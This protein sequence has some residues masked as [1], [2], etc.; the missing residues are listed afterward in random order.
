MKEIK[1]YREG[2]KKLKTLKDIEFESD[3]FKHNCYPHVNEIDGV[4]QFKLRQEAIKWIKEDE[5][6]ILTDKNSDMI[7]YSLMRRWKQRFN[8]TDEDL[9]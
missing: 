4:V 3:D 1:E 7:I 2:D 9:K 8:L 5:K 6:L